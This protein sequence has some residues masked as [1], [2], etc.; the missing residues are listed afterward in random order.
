M[1]TEDLVED[2]KDTLKVNR[3]KDEY[4]NNATKPLEYWSQL[5]NIE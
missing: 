2:G 5:P 4:K 1:Y 3:N